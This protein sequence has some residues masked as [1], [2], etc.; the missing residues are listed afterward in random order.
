MAVT[1]LVALHYN[2]AIRKNIDEI[3]SAPIGRTGER[4]IVVAEMGDARVGL[5]MRLD[6]RLELLDSVGTN[7]ASITQES[8]APNGHQLT[9][10]THQ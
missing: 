9:T 2:Y 6:H 3:R 7:T 1:V 4:L 8:L 5:Q 10:P